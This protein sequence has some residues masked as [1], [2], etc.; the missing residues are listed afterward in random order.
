MPLRSFSGGFSSKAKGS[1]KNP[2]IQISSQKLPAGFDRGPKAKPETEAHA[3]GKTASLWDPVSRFPFPEHPCAR[4][5]RRDII[6]L[7]LPDEISGSFQVVP[8]LG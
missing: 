2:L 4:R 5:I 3:E 7:R 6:Q 8:S 1:P